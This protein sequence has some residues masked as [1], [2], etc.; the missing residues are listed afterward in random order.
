MTTQP[1]VLSAEQ[2]CSVTTE[3]SEIGQ[4]SITTSLAL[5]LLPGVAMLI[6]VALLAPLLRRQGWPPIFAGKLAIL[7]VLV[8]V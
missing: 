5:H 1:L 2:S 3:A 8:P 7:V 6:F 4:H